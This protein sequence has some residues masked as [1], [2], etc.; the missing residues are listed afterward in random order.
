MVMMHFDKTP[1][2]RDLFGVPENEIQGQFKGW[3]KNARY[4]VEF[5]VVVQIDTTNVSDAEYNVSPNIVFMSTNQALVNIYQTHSFTGSLAEF[6]E[7]CANQEASLQFY[8]D[9]LVDRLNTARGSAGLSGGWYI[10][11]GLDSRVINVHEAA[12]A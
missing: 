5:T 10:N 4:T 7:W 2:Q 1:Y 12:E 9:N 8:V 3:E 11:H 6:R